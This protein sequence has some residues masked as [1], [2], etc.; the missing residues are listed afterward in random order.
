[1]VSTG[2]RHRMAQ[3]IRRIPGLIR[4][5]YYPYRLVQPKY[6]VGVIGIVFNDED[7]VLLVEHVFHPVIPWGLPGG[8]V[9]NNENPASA[10]QRELREEL[11]LQV[12]AQKLIRMEKTEYNHLDMAFLCHASNGIGS[13]SFELIGYRWCDTAELPQLHRFHYDA[14]MLAKSMR[15]AN[16]VTAH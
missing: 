1:M 12:E 10:V 14:I 7:K 5:M 9:N 2:F 4:L 3:T 6:T 13:L 8:W 15:E 11:E 16:Y